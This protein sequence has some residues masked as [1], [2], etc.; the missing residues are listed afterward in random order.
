[1]ALFSFLAAERG[2]FFVSDKDNCYDHFMKQK[3]RK[4][5]DSAHQIY[6]RD[7]IGRLK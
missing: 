6:V 4:I 1:M 3:L 2:R 5:F 7:S